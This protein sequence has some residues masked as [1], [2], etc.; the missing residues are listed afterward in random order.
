MRY[1]LNL[2]G[3]IFTSFICAQSNSF[4]KVTSFSESIQQ[5]I[6]EEIEVE[7][8]VINSKNYSLLE[9][10]FLKDNKTFTYSGDVASTLI[11]YKDNLSYSFDAR[12]N[13][14]ESFRLR[15]DTLVSTEKIVN[16]NGYSCYLYNVK[17][18]P[19]VLI[20]ACKKLSEII[21]PGIKYFHHVPIGGIVRI[22]IQRKSSKLVYQLIRNEKSKKDLTPYIKQS[23]S[24]Q[25]TP[26]EARSILGSSN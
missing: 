20:Y 12:L 16:Y 2:M 4:Y 11:N 13:V 10:R 19:N 25:I 23:E 22:E 17:N 8:S 21:N 6:P 26:K 18:E 9:T 5:G 14:L 1:I 3:V 24:S 7:M 15:I